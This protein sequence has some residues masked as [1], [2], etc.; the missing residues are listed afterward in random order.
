MKSRKFDKKLNLNKL[1]IAGLNDVKAG[2]VIALP[3]TYVDPCLDTKY[4][5]TCPGWTACPYWAC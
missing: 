2:K 1:T 5:Y 3:N 4:A